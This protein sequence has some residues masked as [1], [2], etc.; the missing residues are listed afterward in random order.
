MKYLNSVLTKL[1][2][3]YCFSLSIYGCENSNN[4]NKLKDT[5]LTNNNQYKEKESCLIQINKELITIL[6][7]PLELQDYLELDSLEAIIVSTQSH[8]AQFSSKG[9]QQF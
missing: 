5:E 9:K 8:K 2:I 6:S 3:L 7:K 1:V 4:D